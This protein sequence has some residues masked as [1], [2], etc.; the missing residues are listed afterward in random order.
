MYLSGKG[1]KIPQTGD[2]DFWSYLT[3]N[4]LRVSAHT[5]DG[6]DSELLSP[7]D[8]SKSTAT[9]AAASWAAV[10]GHTGTYKQT[11]TVPSGY[12]VD[13]MQVKFYISS[14]TDTGQEVHPSVRKVT[15]TTYDVYVNDNTLEL[16][17]VYG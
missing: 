11:I 13:S 2:R 9:I 10:T 12:S 16:V 14:A 17:A 7:S 6:V 1:Y 15:A 5:H 8:F 3:F 4:W